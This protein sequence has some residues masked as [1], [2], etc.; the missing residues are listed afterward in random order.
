[1][2]DDA[3]PAAPVMTPAEVQDE[4]ER[5]MRDI[6]QRFGELPQDS[7][8]LLRLL[9]EAD[10]WLVRVLQAPPEGMLNTLRPTMS[11]LI[12]KELLEHPDPDIKVAV[13]SCL[14]EVTRITAPE[15]PYDDDIMKDVFKRIVETF[16]DLDDMDS[17]SFARR[18][19]IL[20]SVATTRCCALML[21]LDLDHLAVDMFRNLFK[22][23]SLDHSENINCCMENIMVFVIEESDNVPPELASCL[24]QNL[25]KEAQETL[26]AAF[27]LAERVVGH[28]KDRL[29]QVFIE[30][31]KDTPLDEYSNIVAL[32]CQDASDAIENNNADVSAKAA[33]GK[34]CE[35]S[36]SDESPQETSKLEQDV[37]CAGQDGT[38]PSSI[39]T[40][41]ISNGGA[42][43]DNVKSTDGPA[44]EQKPELPSGDEQAKI[45]DQL[46]SGDKEVLE[47]AK[48]SD[49]LISGD[50]EMS[51][52][53]ITEPEKSYDL[54]LKKSHRLDSSTVS[55][56]T[57]HPKV[58]KDN[59]SL[60]AS[61]E[62]CPE[63]NDGDDKQLTETGNRA[64]DDA[65]SAVV[66]P[67]RGRPPAAK[68]QEKKPSG[69]KQGSD[70]EP[71]RLDLVSD[72]GRRVTRQMTK[73]DAKSPSTKVA[74][75]ESWK[76]QQ[77][78]N[79]KL[80]KEDPFSD[81]DDD[82]DT[83][84]KEM[85]SASKTDK[86]KGQQEDGGGSKRKRPQEA[87][88]APL[89][90]KNNIL[91]ENLVGSRIKVWWPDDK[92]FY[93]GVVK[94]FDASSKKHKVA[95]DDGDVEVLLLKNEKWEFITEE[96]NSDPDAA[97]D[98][99]RGKSGQGILRQQTKEG[100][101][102][103]PK[104]DSRDPPKKRGRPKGVRSSNS[105]VTSARL[106]G[107]SVEK[108]IQETPKTGSNLKKEGARPSR[109]TGKTRDGVVMASNKNEVGG[110]RS[111]EKSKDEAGNEDQ[112]SK[113]EVKSSE[114]IDG[115]KTN[116]LSTKRKPK[117][118]EGDSSEEEQGSA[119]ASIGKK[120]RRKN[121]K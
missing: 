19:S 38:C 24:L 32:L 55:E 112:D 13:T 44:S 34:I 47:Q 7:D 1:M 82:E 81:E 65:K 106:K 11:A 88:E 40:A 67:K 108:D 37:N 64:A 72:S 71:K 102:G 75:R 26:P 48:I 80:K 104:S 33:E 16:A 86:T 101:T 35:R 20:E 6:G 103:T 9:Q 113:D 54:S 87:E 100:K 109:S 116:G 15:A 119:K 29:K 30:L 49:Q 78:A 85:V 17:P 28:C 43:V 51:E 59:E 23:I 52:P 91:D 4:A 60:V 45:S 46:I 68:S 58:V 92:M 95:Y 73:I 69:N 57:E 115:S 84:L 3:P 70:L 22:A 89:S 5:R 105:P 63:T 79:L 93:D 31:L 114:A 25:K 50:K 90:K 121:H 111:A 61:G 74:E 10:T 66:K 18:A 42:P 36:V 27:G 77:K 107:K 120:R 99:P 117:A 96:Q 76:K 62:L 118:K 98:T 12:T 2:A 41:A 56:I 94:S 8:E 39:P 110:T 14:T 97:S 21:D 83:S 53:V